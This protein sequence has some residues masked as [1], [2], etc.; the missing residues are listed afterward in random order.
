MSLNEV[1]NNLNYVQKILNFYKG[2]TLEDCVK[3]DIFDNLRQH[4]YDNCI[5][6]IDEYYMKMPRYIPSV[7]ENKPWYTLRTKLPELNTYVLLYVNR[8]WHDEDDDPKYVVAKFVANCENEGE[9][10]YKFKQFGPDSFS[11]D[12]V[13]YWTYINKIDKCFKS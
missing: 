8:P 4:S 10:K 13:K 9:I 11:L 12:D 1:Q 3:N 5:I 7:Y 2:I 6:T